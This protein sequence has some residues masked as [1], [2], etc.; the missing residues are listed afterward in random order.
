[1]QDDRSHLP[2]NKRLITEAFEF[3][4]RF[5]FV[6]YTFSGRNANQTLGFLL[7]R[8]MRRAGLKPMGFFYKRLRSCCL[9]AKAR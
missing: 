2:D 5:Y 7:L 4:S 1:M 3:K 9:V 8:R 6:V